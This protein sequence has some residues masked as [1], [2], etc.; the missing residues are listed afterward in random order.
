MSNNIKLRIFPPENT[1]S[2]FA[3]LSSVEE[4]NGTWDLTSDPRVTRIVSTRPT[5][6]NSYSHFADDESSDSS[7]VNTSEGCVIQGTFPSAERIRIR[8]SK[9]IKVLNIPGDSSS[10][11][12]KVGVEDVTGRMVCTVKGQGRSASNPEVEGVLMHV[13]Y[14]GECKGIW[15]PGVATLVGMDVSL[16]AKGSEVAWPQGYSNHWEVSGS[17]GYTGFNHGSVKGTSPAISRAPSLDFEGQGSNPS[18]SQAESTNT[19]LTSK[20]HQGSS[21]SSLLRAPLPSQSTADYSFEASNAN[22]GASE[23]L[24]SVSSLPSTSTNAAPSAFPTSAITLHIDINDINPPVK[25]TFTFNI[26]GT[27]LVTSK[28]QTA[29]LNGSSSSAGSDKNGD[30]TFFLN[31]VRQSLDKTSDLT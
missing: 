17:D 4:E 29:R 10:G 21:T 16:R 31:L 8:W 23:T 12:R 1:S 9:P 3:S 13:Q 22:L 25:G 26:S 15:F 5:R 2:S 14:Q 11:R 27:I 20:T 6:A 19:Y 18:A 30:L 7:V 28:S 24:S